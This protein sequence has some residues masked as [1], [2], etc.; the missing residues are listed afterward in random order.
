ML[1]WTL[2]CF[3]VLLLC[4]AV[5]V[6]FWSPSLFRAKSA[7]NSYSTFSVDIGKD[8]R[9]LSSEAVHQDGYAITWDGSMSDVPADYVRKPASQANTPGA[10]LGVKNEKT[11]EKQRAAGTAVSGIW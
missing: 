8:R 10:V 6:P 2:F 7:S 9:V 3:F 11:R 5:E 4:V 1:V